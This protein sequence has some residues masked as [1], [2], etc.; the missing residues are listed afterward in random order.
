MTM[1]VEQHEESVAR[2]DVRRAQLLDSAAG[3]FRVRGYAAASMRDIAATAGIQAGS[4]YYHFDS[5]EDLLVAVHEQGIRRIVAEV[6]TAAAGEVAPW[7]RLQAAMTAHLRGLLDGGDYAQVVIRELP[8]EPGP[9]RDKL[10]RLRDH[11][12]TLFRGL[13]DALPLPVGKSRQYLRLMILGAM[14]W[15]QTW[16]RADGDSPAEI[17]EAFIQLVKGPEHECD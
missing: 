17:A 5:K 6:E 12:E 7:R 2:R 4:M 9:V 15:S 8:H 14:N 10:I 16:Y 1:P 13:V 11:Y 3:H